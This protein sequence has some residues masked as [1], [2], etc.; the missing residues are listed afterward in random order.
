[1]SHR[2]VDG[3]IVDQLVD[4]ESFLHRF[5]ATNSGTTADLSPADLMVL[6]RHD[7]GQVFLSPLCPSL[8]KAGHKEKPLL[9][10]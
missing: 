9:N 4:T 3:Q 5:P 6:V 2:H 1:M 7:Q 8:I 10:L